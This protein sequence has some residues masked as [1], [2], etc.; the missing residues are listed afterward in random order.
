MHFEDLFTY[1]F[2][3]L[4]A[5]LAAAAM[6]FFARMLHQKTGYQS[7]ELFLCSRYQLTMYLFH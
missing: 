3:F 4:F 5:S 7:P 2:G 1:T 6:I